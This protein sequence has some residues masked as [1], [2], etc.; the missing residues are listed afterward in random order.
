MA[1]CA[2]AVH[3]AMD[4][5]KSHTYR[6][7]AFGSGDAGPVGYVE[8]GAVRLLKNWPMAHVERTQL[9][10]ETIAN[11][12]RWPRVEI[13]M[14][15]ADA[16]GGLID[17]LLSQMQAGHKDPVRGIALEAALICAQ[18]A[19]ISVVRATRCAQGRVISAPGNRFPDSQG[20]S[21]VKAR[22]ALMLSLI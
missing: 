16:G 10:I 11:L 19:G 22:I 6:L 4:V 17:A 7:D 9:A 15:Y 1:V 3:S 21:P 8:E 14:N 5:Q 2:G 18:D 13:V 12:M 20:L